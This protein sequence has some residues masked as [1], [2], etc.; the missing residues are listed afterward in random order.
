MIASPE[1]TSSPTRPTIDLT[2]SFS[3]EWTT[4]HSVDGVTNVIADVSDTGD[5]SGA[6]TIASDPPPGPEPNAGDS[7]VRKNVRR[8]GAT[9]PEHDP[10]T[11]GKLLNQ[12]IRPLEF[13]TEW[14][15]L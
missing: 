14:Y 5:I 13:R 9:L 10:R 2:I 12:A 3:A 11:T 6:L 7:P 4:N 1:S 15:V 8:K